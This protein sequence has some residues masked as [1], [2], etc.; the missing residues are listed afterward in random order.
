MKRAVEAPSTITTRDLKFL[1]L[2]AYI[3]LG[4]T[5]QAVERRRDTMEGMDELS[6]RGF[7]GVAR[8]PVDL[9]HRAMMS[10][11]VRTYL[12]TADHLDDLKTIV[13]RN[14]TSRDFVTSDDPAIVTNR[15][16]LQRL[17]DNN[18]G[19][20]SSGA[21]LLLPLTPRLLLMCYDS[22]TYTAPDRRG[23]WIDTDK[24]TDVLALNEFQ[25]LKCGA[26]IYFRRW[27]EFASIRRD[28]GDVA[29]RRPNSSSDFWVGILV[30]ENEF[31]EVYRKA[32][33]EE[34][35]SRKPR[36]V[37]YSPSYPTPSRWFSKLRYRPAPVGYSNGSAVGYLRKEVVAK[38]PGS[39]RRI[40]IPIVAGSS[41]LNGPREFMYR[42]RERDE[43]GR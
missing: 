9:S 11:S 24:E 3:Q 40:T 13:V 1:R 35:A 2:F 7:N 6:H 37:S 4:R 10:G 26:N 32:T 15:V 12:E 41:G 30:R 5:Q 8:E 36:I 34:L 18:F 42:R 23:L 25:F 28:F 22:D 29:A 27:E 17:K 31:E 20:G 19:V 33:D 38:K 16:H 43:R 14:R 39:F 21:Q